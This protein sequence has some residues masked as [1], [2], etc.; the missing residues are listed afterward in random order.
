MSVGHALL[1]RVASQALFCKGFSLLFFAQSGQ[2][3][4]FEIFLTS[5][6]LC[7]YLKTVEIKKIQK[8]E[9]KY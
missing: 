5:I 6:P 3:N 4:H 9:E 2:L 8:K 1:G 7:V